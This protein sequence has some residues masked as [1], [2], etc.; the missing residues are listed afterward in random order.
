[1]APPPCPLC[2]ATAWM[3]LTE[4]RPKRSVRT[5]GGVVAAPLSKHHCDGCGLAMRWGVAE[6][7]A[8]LYADDYQLYE[9]RPRA[10]EF[11]PGRYGAL[12]D[13][14]VDLWDAAPPKRVLEVGCGDGGLLKALAARW[15]S[16]QAVGLE[17]STTAV[18]LAQAQDAPV[19]QGMVGESLPAV[20]AQGGFDL[21]Y[22]IHVIEH[23]PDPSR[24]L[25]ELG[26]L[27]A[28]GGRILITCPDGAVAHA[29]LIHPDHLFSMTP[30]HLGA[31]A[32]RAGMSV[33]AQT[34]CPHGAGAEFSQTLVCKPGAVSLAPLPP[35]PAMRSL[36]ESRQ[37][38][39]AAWRDLEAQFLSRLEEDQPLYCFGAGGWAA[40]IAGY[41]PDLWARVKT[42]AID[43]GAEPSVQG[44][45]VAD[46][47]DLAGAPRQFLAAV[48]PAIQGLIR[49]KL[50]RDGHAVLPWPETIEA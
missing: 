26:G 7:P 48:N 33:I 42:C 18:A 41:C 24:F 15:P 38:Y 23:T 2:R 6:D 34:E 19:L 11:D 45:P 13:M 17:P 5:D 40:N 35:N 8:A 12:V 37:A 22:S 3:A 27:L 21:I 47:A 16:A 43:G 20:V 28:P 36:A 32:R 25:A 14:V 31:F 9:N 10:L 50:E 4:I 29:E 1:M 30:E 49:A 39:L 46:Y 44:K